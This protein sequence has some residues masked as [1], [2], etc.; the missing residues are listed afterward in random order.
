MTVVNYMILVG[1]DYLA[2]RHVGEPLGL[3]KIALASFTGYACSYN[4]GAT[5][6]ARRSAID[7]IRP[8]ACRR[9]GFC[10]CWSFW[11]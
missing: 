3:G 6:A 1:Y 2:V 11:G 4:I 5:I 9:C 8:G 7:S 10:S